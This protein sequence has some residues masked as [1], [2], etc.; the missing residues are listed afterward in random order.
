MPIVDASLARRAGDALTWKAF[1]LAGI[2]GIFLVRT[3]ILARLLSPDDFGLL[4]IATVAVGVLIRVTELGMTPAL[5]HYPD[6]EEVHYNA[7]WTVNMARALCVSG[8]LFVVAPAIAGLF[9]EPR[10]ADILRFLAVKPLIDAS[11]S[12]KT[13]ALMR[14]LQYRRLA[15]VSLPAVAVDTVVAVAL[16]SRLGVWALVAGALAGAVAGVLSSYVLAPH[17]PRILVTQDAVR[18]L[19]RYGRWVFLTGLVAVAASSLT[20]LVISRQLGVVELGLYFLAAKLAFLPHEVANQ[21]GGDVAF[22]LYARLQH[23]TGR[24]A[25]AF[26]SILLGTTAILLPLY[27]LLI[28]LAPRLV[29]DVL[30]ER[31]IGTETLIQLLAAV[32]IVGVF[33]DVTAPLFRGLGHPN[34]IFCIEVW[35]SALIVGLLWSLTGHYGAPGAALAWLIAIGSSQFVSFVLA[36]RILARP[37]EGSAVPLAAVLV[38]SLAGV[39]TALA[40]THVV[41]GLTGLSMALVAASCVTMGALWFSD[42]HFQLSLRADLSV[43]F[44]QMA[45]LVGLASVGPLTAETR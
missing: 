6:V 16:A 45:R 4:A 5:V 37:L 32:G 3:L 27:L 35:Q 29:A 33:G 25:R 22:S 42:E 13:A 20:Q 18:P 24:I 15:F 38:A 36:C 34:W 7:A 23:D 10:A 30:G 19:I 2:K 9:A 11:A 41:A 12:I 40:V 43:A 28:C 17:R 1:Q 8:V 14:N 21:V 44:P 26:R 39:G 31:W